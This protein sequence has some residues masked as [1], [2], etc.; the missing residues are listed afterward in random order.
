MSI[1]KCVN[2]SFVNDVYREYGTDTDTIT[3]LPKTIIGDGQPISSYT[4]KGNMTQ[5]GTP[6]PSNPVY[7]QETG[8]KTANLFDTGTV[9][10]G[11]I[12]N[13]NVGYSSN[14]TELTVT[15]N[16]ISCTTNYAFRGFSS[17]FIPISTANLYMSYESS[18]ATYIVAVY[19]DSSKTWLNSDVSIPSQSKYA[20]LTVPTGA[21]YIRFSFTFSTAGTYTVSNFMLNTGS[22]VLP[23]EPYGYKIPILSNGTT[24]PAYLGQVQ[25]T[26]QIKQLVLTGEEN[27]Q[28]GGGSAPYRVPVADFMGTGTEI[29]CI[30]SHYLGVS[31]AATWSAYDY[32]ISFTESD[33]GYLRIRD[34]DYANQSTAQFKAYL[35]SQYSAGTPVTVWYVLATPTTG[36]VNEPIRKI[37]TYTDTVTNPITIPTS[38]TAQTF[39]VDTT[40]KPS[41]VSLTYHGWHEHEDTK[42]TTP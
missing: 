29:I 33:T 19:Y 16:S 35:A 3:S 5:S 38:G 17:D 31:S 4:I 20:S 24:Y 1:K 32:M 9:V 40:L 7:P 36:I 2:G 22:T 37:G 8:E 28:K 10:K 21:A 30:S 26:R 23:Y 27:I 13:G 6:T 18:S 11:R 12:D 39:D 25:T 14:T 42:Y 41:E 34:V 15:T